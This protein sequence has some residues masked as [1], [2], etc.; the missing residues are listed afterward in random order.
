MQ[1]IGNWDNSYRQRQTV[2]TEDGYTFT[3]QLEYKVN[4]QS[5]FWSFGYN[6]FAVNGIRLVL[7]SNILRRFKSQIPFGISCTTD[8]ALLADP[9]DQNDLVTER[10]KLLTL[11][12][13]DVATIETALYG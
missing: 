10:I 9:F 6:D 7:D 4:Q 8:D 1:Q 2:T 5:W 12:A 11:T 13:S 3:F